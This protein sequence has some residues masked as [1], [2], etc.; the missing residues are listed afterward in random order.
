MTITS[1]EQLNS[2][3]AGYH[4]RDHGLLAI[5]SQSGAWRYGDGQHHHPELPVEAIGLDPYIRRTP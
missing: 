2:L 3:P 4:I 5:K 1:P